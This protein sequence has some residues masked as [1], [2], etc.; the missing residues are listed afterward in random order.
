[1]T[2][3][4][5][6]YLITLIPTQGPTFT[7]AGELGG[8]AERRNKQRHGQKRKYLRDFLGLRKR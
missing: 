7:Q 5:F 2:G 3:I 8:K 1:M 4:V 6:Q